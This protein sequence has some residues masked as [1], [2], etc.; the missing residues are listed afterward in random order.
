MNNVIDCSCSECQ[1]VRDLLKQREKDG[2]IYLGGLEE[3]KEKI[4]K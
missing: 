2:E 3:D 4:R 1:M